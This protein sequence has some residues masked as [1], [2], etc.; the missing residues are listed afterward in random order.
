MRLDFSDGRWP[1]VAVVPL[2]GD[3]GCQEGATISRPSSVKDAHH[4]RSLNSSLYFMGVRANCTKLKE[5]LNE[6]EISNGCELTEQCVQIQSW[7][8]W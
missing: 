8:G 1:N 6:G 2:A 7:N 4:T 3:N 5:S